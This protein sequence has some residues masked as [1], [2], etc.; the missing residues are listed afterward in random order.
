A[1]A[2][3]R[4]MISTLYL[5]RRLR[6]NQ[7]VCLEVFAGRKIWKLT[8][9]LAARESIETPLGRLPSLRFDGE[10]VRLDDANVRRTAH[11]WISDD[12]RRLPL[13]AIGEV[14]GKTIR[15]QLV[16]APGA[17]RAARK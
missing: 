4:D 3:V 14:K 11:V 17:R 12:E 15:A 13:A 2:G 9:E 8:G 10:A 7:P 1:D 6:L 5:L 16:S